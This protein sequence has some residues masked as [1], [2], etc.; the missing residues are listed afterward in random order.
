MVISKQMKRNYH[1]CHCLVQNPEYMKLGED[2]STSN[3]LVLQTSEILMTGAS[4][5]QTIFKMNRLIF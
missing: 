3:L 1:I 5:M 4:E 2:A